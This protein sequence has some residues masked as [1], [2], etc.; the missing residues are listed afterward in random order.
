[1]RLKWGAFDRILLLMFRLPDFCGAWL[2]PLWRLA[3][4]GDVVGRYEVRRRW[5]CG[6][7]AASVLRWADPAGAVVLWSDLGATLAHETG[8]GNDI[9]SGALKRDDSASDTLYFKFHVDPL[10][11]V[12][13]EEYFA[14]FQL[15]EGEVERLAVGNSLKAWAYSAFNTATNGEFNKVFGD[16]DLR[17]SQ[18]E[19]SSPGVF[20]PYELPRRGIERTIVFKVEYVPG[21]EDRVTVWLNPDLTP[22]ATE[23]GQPE[24]LKTIFNA[25]ASFDAIH[26][27]HGGGGGGWTFSDM[28]IATSFSDFVS[29]GSAAPG[30]A[31]PRPGRG[32]GLDFPFL[33]AG[34]RA[35]AELGAGAGANARWLPLDR[36]R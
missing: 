28:E 27:R 30:G 9:L 6:L 21:G 24:S 5:L 29:A 12:G 34:A 20:L 16:M 1:M 19:S 22:G 33:A 15:Y 13:T 4:G 35:A 2:R 3:S 25:N 8:A 17:S 14:A 31:T 10:S 26:L 11:D 23:A 32:A 18:P 7:M 36:E